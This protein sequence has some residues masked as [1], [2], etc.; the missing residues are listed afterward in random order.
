VVCQLEPCVDGGVYLAT[1]GGPALPEQA[2]HL[3]TEQ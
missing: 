2:E 1:A 3:G